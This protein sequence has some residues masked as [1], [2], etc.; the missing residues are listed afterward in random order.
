MGTLGTA[1]GTISYGYGDT[2]W[3]DKLTSYNGKAIT[4]D[5]VGNPLT[6]GTDTSF[7]WT[8]GRELASAAVKGNNISYSYDADGLRTK[9][10]VNGVASTYLYDGGQL[11]YEKRGDKDI[12]YFYNADGQVTGIQYNGLNYY[13]TFNS[14]GDII[15]LYNGAGELRAAYEYNEWGKLLSVTDGAGNPITDSNH[16]GQINPIRYRGYYY[17]NESGLYYVV[18]R[19]YDPQIGRFINADD[20]SML[21]VEQ[22]NLIQYNLF[23]YCL[24]N[25][26]NMTD[27]GGYFAEK[28]LRQ[29]ETYIT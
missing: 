2:N 28:E 1:T 27:V 9:K 4:Y 16:I 24:N 17:D 21:G 14:R 29:T 12:F 13:F 7:A 19:Y 11:A 10:I 5:N 26:V 22:G 15:G 25:P 18:S 23:A 20:T 3:K 6:V 8:N